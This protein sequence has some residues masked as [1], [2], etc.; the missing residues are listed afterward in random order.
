MCVYVCV[1][2]NTYLY[3]VCIIINYNT[4]HCLLIFKIIICE[5]FNVQL[6]ASDIILQICLLNKNHVHVKFND[7]FFFWTNTTINI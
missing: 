5:H 4:M 7:L 3:F 2:V 6:L 1:R